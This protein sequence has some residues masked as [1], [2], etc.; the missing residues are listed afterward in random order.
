M[1]SVL[2]RHHPITRNGGFPSEILGFASRERNGPPLLN[3]LEGLM[4]FDVLFGYP[5]RLAA[6]DGFSIS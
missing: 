1:R 2:S 4:Y 5:E 6:G 3:P